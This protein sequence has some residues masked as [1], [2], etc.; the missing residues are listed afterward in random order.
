MYKTLKIQ[1]VKLFVSEMVDDIKKTKVIELIEKI[2]VE[3]ITILKEI[4]MDRN[5]YLNDVNL[6]FRGF[7]LETK[8]FQHIT[9][10]FQYITK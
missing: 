4:I 1:S 10:E 9:K 2:K 8:V 3:E 7:F 6:L 5:I